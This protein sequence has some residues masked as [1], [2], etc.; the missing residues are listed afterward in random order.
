MRISVGWLLLLGVMVLH[1]SE[2]SGLKMTVRYSMNGQP[3]EQTLYVQSDRRRMEYRNSVGGARRADGSFDARYG[4]RLAMITRCDLGQIYDL[5]LD[6]REYVTAPY[7]PKP[8]N[9]EEMEAHGLKMPEFNASAKPTLRV[10]TTT[11]DTGERKEI[12]GHTARH[13]ITTRKEIP[14]EGSHRDAQQM[15][16]E[17][18]YIDLDTSIT[19]DMHR[20]PGK[21]AYLHV[22]LFSISGATNAP[23]EK[24]EF[25]DNGKPETGFAIESKISSQNTVLLPDGSK[26]EHTYNSEMQ[27]MDLVEG[28]L[29]PGLFSVPPGFR[30]VEHIERNPSPT[31]SEQWNAIWERFKAGVTGLFR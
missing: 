5:N 6:S 29:D 13:V 9:N 28:P 23:L 2:R 25:V 20:S 22:A 4:P 17:A 8:L 31:L 14:L 26:R 27:V 12:F 1:A 11:V 30:Q 16:T 19:C 24:V 15:V 10:E 7:P 3:S 21:H 18:W